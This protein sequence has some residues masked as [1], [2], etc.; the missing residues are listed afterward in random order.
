MEVDA[1]YLAKPCSYQ[2]TLKNC[3]DGPHIETDHQR[4][5]KHL[6]SGEFVSRNK[7]AQD[8]SRGSA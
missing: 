6:T 7:K 3:R 2:L 8:F 4:S 5:R 1:L